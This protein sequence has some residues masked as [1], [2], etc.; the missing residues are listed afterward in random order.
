MY[1]LF[2]VMCWKLLIWPR[3]INWIGLQEGSSENEESDQ[4]FNPG[5]VQPS[6][7]SATNLPVYFSS[8]EYAH[9]FSH[10][11]VKSS[12]NVAEAVASPR[13]ARMARAAPCLERRPMLTSERTSHSVM[14]PGKAVGVQV[15]ISRF[16][17]GVMTANT[18]Q[19]VVKARWHPMIGCQ[20]T[21]VCNSVESA[22]HGGKQMLARSNIYALDWISMQVAGS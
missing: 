22:G 5:P 6:G 15:A 17:W 18:G 7:V 13:A 12:K 20:A 1:A 8:A 14:C 11:E 3:A 21:A 10:P 4:T 16:C 9:R 2:V 19:H